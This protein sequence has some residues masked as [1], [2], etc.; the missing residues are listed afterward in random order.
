M[1]DTDSNPNFDAPPESAEKPL[2]FRERMI[3]ARAARDAAGM[4]TER[5]DP[6]ERARRNPQSLRMAITAK[7]W[8]CQGGDDDPHPRWRIGNCTAPECP[9]YSHRPYQKHTGDPVPASLRM[10]QENPE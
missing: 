8:D 10:G 9:L 6:M 3:A 5:L 2:G 4:V 7:C 1:L